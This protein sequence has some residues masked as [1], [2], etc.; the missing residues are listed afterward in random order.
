MKIIALLSYVVVGFL[1]PLAHAQIE[2]KSEPLDMEMV[3]ANN[4]FGYTDEEIQK[5]FGAPEVYEYDYTGFAKNLVKAPPAPGVHP[6]VLFYEE[7]LSALREKFVKTKPGKLAMDG[8]RAGIEDLIIGPKA[9]FAKV[10]EDAVNGVANAE[11]TNVEPACAIVC[12]TFRALIDNDESGA[13]KAAA[14]LTTLAKIQTAALEAAWA[15]DDKKDGAAPRLRDYQRYKGYTYSGMIG[16]GYDFAFNSMTPA[17]REVV[18]GLLLKA[19]VGMTAIGCEAL[20]ATPA[21]TSNWIPMHMPMILLAASVE[22]EPGSDPA[23]FKRFVSG[24]KHY[25]GAGF[26]PSGEMFESMGK[27]FLCAENLM[28]IGNR[29]DNLIALKK[30]RQQVTNYYLNA[31]DPWGGK[32]TFFDSLG[33][34]GNITPMQDVMVVKRM[35]P[36]DPAVDFVYRNSVGEDYAFFGAK[37]RFNHPLHLDGPLMRAIFCVEYDESKTFAQAQAAAVKSKAFTYY[38][39]DTG[40]LITRD[41]WTS[42]ATVLH[43]LTRCVAGGHVYADRSSFNLIAMGRHWVIYKPMRQVE[44]HYAPK[45]RSVILIDGHGPGYAM[46]KSVGLSDQ[47]VATFIATDTK[48]AF[49]WTTGGNNRFPKGG[50]PSPFTGNDFRLNKSPKPWMNISWSDL[51]HWQTSKKGSELW[52]PNY[53]VE[54]AFRTA[55][56]VRGK[57]PY[58]L[59]ID[60]YQKD[61]EPHTYDWGMI[62]E[63]DVVQVSVTGQ[64]VILGEGKTG[65]EARYLLVR[66]LNAN[67][68][69][70]GS[71]TVGTYDLPNPSQKPIT[72]NRLSV[73]AKSVAPDFR[74]L[75]FPY[76]E[77]EEQPMTRWNAN[78]TK[79]SIEWSDQKDVVE[80][81]QP[82]DGRSRIKIL[83]NQTELANLP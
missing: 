55:G 78:K 16:L 72:L 14:A 12:E 40:N 58:A 65:A 43:F 57:H 33:G 64:D 70:D 77:G 81:T 49:D 52:L 83:R 76:R 62:L 39:D 45:N 8:L 75:L 50:V 37:A 71:I 19:T 46:G 35:F 69:K 5:L 25:L 36:Q 61:A 68:L 2:T 7:D 30:I 10:Y 48:P 26:F 31:M 59:I 82:A 66:V 24:Y 56:L 4:N 74:T 79:L 41:A 11:I 44:E 60:D 51:P 18:R 73:Q 80:F 47:P 42:N 27:N 28:V 23:T 63:D 21:A 34:R 38:S 29:G 3:K 54:R 9:K 17:Q 67:G 22:G 6:R 20:P 32:F 1:A 15:K 53:P 13:K